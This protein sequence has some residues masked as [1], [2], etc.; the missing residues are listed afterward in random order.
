[1]TGPAGRFLG[2]PRS[3][4]GRCAWEGSEVVQDALLLV[5][6][7]V[8]VPPLLLAEEHHGD[9]HREVLLPSGRLL[10]HRVRGDLLAHDA[11]EQRSHVLAEPVLLLAHHLEGVG[12]GVIDERPPLGRGLLVPAV[13][14]LIAHSRFAAS[15]ASALRSPLV[16]VMW[17]AMRSCLKRLTT[18]TRPLVVA[19]T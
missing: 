15:S 12:G 2:T 13:L 8:D 3:G 17:P 9:R 18:C 1:R 11:V 19:S 5:Q 6:L 10:A 4:V 16:M 14:P 7:G